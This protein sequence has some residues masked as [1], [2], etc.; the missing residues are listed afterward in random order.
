MKFITLVLSLL[1]FASYQTE[2]KPYSL[3]NTEVLELKDQNTEREYSLYVKY[4]V[5]YDSAKSY[6]VIYMTDAG[7]MFP[8]LSGALGIPM[9]AGKI[10]NAFLVGISWQKN[11]WSRKS[12]IRDYT[13]H[14]NKEWKHK[15]GGAQQHL[16]FIRDHVIPEVD[17]RFSTDKVNRTYIGNSL[18]GLFGGYVLLTQPD[19]FSAYV[20]SSPSFWFHNEKILSE[21]K[22]ANL[23]KVEAK[24]YISVGAL[25]VPATKETVHD[26]VKVAE[27]FYN[28]LVEKGNPELVT[29][30]A[31]VAEANH[32]VAFATSSIQGLYWLSKH[33]KNNSGKIQ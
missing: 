26:M 11:I 29:K 20:L 23:S 22:Q 10:D 2:A 8:T 15:T 9:S 3:P 17:R 18:G 12:R 31:T 33:S 32:E 21:L 28:G 5:R 16:A 24:V 14:Y 13:H 6:P 1:V 19:T 4:P 7:Y 27:T 25:E 30:F